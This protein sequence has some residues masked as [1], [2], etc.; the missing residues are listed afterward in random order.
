MSGPTGISCS[1]SAATGAREPTI[2]TWWAMHVRG[3]HESTMR[4]KSSRRTSGS[5]MLLTSCLT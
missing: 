5:V 3:E 1:T 2:P 4:S